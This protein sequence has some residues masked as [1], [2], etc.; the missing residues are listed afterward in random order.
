LRGCVGLVVAVGALVLFLVFSLA[1][2]LGGRLKASRASRSIST[3]RSRAS[4]QLVIGGSMGM[5]YCVLSPV[6]MVRAERV[7]AVSFAL[8][9]AGAE[10]W[11]WCWRYRESEEAWSVFMWV[12]MRAFRASSFG[13]GLVVEVGLAIF[14]AGVVVRFL[15]FGRAGFVGV[16]S[17]ELRSYGDLD[18]DR[19]NSFPRE[20]LRVLSATS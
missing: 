16:D 10:R 1:L 13:S 4:L 7:M 17:K 20:M 11:L 15:N 18:G 6:S 9:A 3:I 19:E 8:A 5:V 14:I 12:I 2:S